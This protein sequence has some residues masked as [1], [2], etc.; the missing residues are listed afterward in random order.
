MRQVEKARSALAVAQSEHQNAILRSLWLAKAAD[1]AIKGRAV[2]VGGAAVNLHTGSYRP[3]DVDMCALLDA[4]DRRTLVELGFTNSQGDH[5]EYQFE[6]G[7]LWLLEFPDSQVDGDTELIDLSS[8]DRLAVIS[9]ESLIVDRLLQATDGSRVTFEEAVRLCV[10]VYTSANWSWVESE[11]ERRD[12]IEPGLRL[13]DTFARVMEEV[14]V[15]LER[16]HEV[17]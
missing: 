14:R 2:L 8:E 7:E 13:A 9:K 17:G 5:F 1:Y 11:I 12:S 3:T 10:V 15:Q 16:S 4:S 6:D